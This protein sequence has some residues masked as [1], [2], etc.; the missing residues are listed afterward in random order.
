MTTENIFPLVVYPETKKIHI[1]LTCLFLAFGL[2]PFINGIIKENFILCLSLP[3][4]FILIYIFNIFTNGKYELEDLYSHGKQISISIEGIGIIEKE[5]SK[6]YTWDKIKEVE[7]YINA[8]EG[9][10][11]NEHT[12]TGN[13]NK[14]IVK[15]N[16]NE[17]YAFDFYIKK[18]ED[19]ENLNELMKKTILPIVYKLKKIKFEN[20][21]FIHLNYNEKQLFKEK[22]NISHYSGKMHYM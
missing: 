3:I 2:G 8:Y 19:F 20:L 6:F 12:A 7:F 4:V 13:E 14:I 9:M 18:C 10:M 22:Y 15:I 21:I 16:Q 11:R 17:L 1:I 5:S